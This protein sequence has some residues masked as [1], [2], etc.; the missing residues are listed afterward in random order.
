MIFMNNAHVYCKLLFQISVIQKFV[1]VLTV[2]LQTG[3]QQPNVSKMPIKGPRRGQ[4]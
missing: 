4:S 2:M 3:A 1:T